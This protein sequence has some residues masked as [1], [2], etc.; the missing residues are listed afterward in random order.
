VD[1]CIRAD[2]L[3]AREPLSMT[4]TV[5]P[6]PRGQTPGPV[7]SPSEDDGPLSPRA[8]AAS[9]GGQQRIAFLFDA[10]LTAF[11]MMGNVSMGLKSHAVTMFEVGKLAHGSVPS[12]LE[13]LAQVHTVSDSDGEAQQYFDHAVNLLHTLQ[14]LRGPTATDR[15]GLAV[16]D[17][18]AGVGTCA[19]SLG[20]RMQKCSMLTEANAL[21]ETDLV[22]VESLA[23][24]DAAARL[25][26]LARSYSLLI[27]MAPIGPDCRTVHSSMP[28]HFGPAVPEVHPSAAA[29]TRG[30]ADVV[31][32]RR[33]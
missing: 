32:L 23:S 21:P 10:T 31:C 28:S 3:R 33:R 2:D 25:R 24:L 27:S 29:D 1:A 15:T 17:A 7:R 13:E 6:T 19:A 20:A 9:D 26:V 22:R 30:V 8:T 16:L 5:S 11:L 4:L 18:A 14:F 12:L